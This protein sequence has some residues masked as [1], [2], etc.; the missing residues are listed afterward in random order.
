MG[1]ATNDPNDYLAIGKQSARNTEATTFHFTKHLEGSEI[2]VEPD[3]ESHREGGDGQ[4]IGLVHRKFV[5]TDAKINTFARPEIAGIA[6]GAVLGADSV[7]VVATAGGILADHTLTPAAS[8]PYLTIEQRYA[9]ERERTVNNVCSQLEIEF[10]AGMPIKL[11]QTYLCGGTYRSPAVAQTPTRETAQPFFWPN[12]SVVVT[13]ASGAEVTKAKQTVKRNLDDDIITTGLN[14]SD[15]VSQSQDYDIDLTIKYENKTLYAEAQRK[16]GTHVPIN[17]ADIGTL[18]LDI[19]AAQGSHSLR[20]V[21]PVIPIMA[22]KINRLD[23][24][25]KTMYM[26]LGCIG[27]KG[28]THPFF[29]VVRNGATAPYA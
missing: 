28:A 27:W 6:L 23:P 4:Q 19:F 11:E 21:N 5:K 9:D 12:A 1:R 10:T 18:G 20:L 7:N 24:D 3:M 13:G 26:D 15:L 2:E 22:A 14:R 8:Q 16:G 17:P 29:A 25:G